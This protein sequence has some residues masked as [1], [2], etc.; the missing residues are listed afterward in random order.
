VHYGAD[1]DNPCDS[2]QTKTESTAGL[3]KTAFLKMMDSVLFNHY[4]HK[5][6]EVKID[7]K[8]EIQVLIDCSFRRMTST[9][10]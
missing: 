9:L 1:F 8:N 10:H 7:I 3:D 6:S 2:Y 5:E 4:T